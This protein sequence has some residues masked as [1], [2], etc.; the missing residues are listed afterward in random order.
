M[1]LGVKNL[2][3]RHRQVAVRLT[4]R[5]SAT[6][7]GTVALILLHHSL[8]LLLEDSV[9][10]FFALLLHPLDISHF[11]ALKDMIWQHAGSVRAE[12]VRFGS[13]V[14]F[15][16]LVI[17][18]VDAEQIVLTFESHV[19]DEVFFERLDRDE[20][21]LVSSVNSS[22]GADL[23]TLLSELSENL[24]DLVISVLVRGAA[25]S[26]DYLGK[27]VEVD[28]TLF[29]ESSFVH[30]LEQV[31]KRARLARFERSL[32][33]QLDLYGAPQDILLAISKLRW[34]L[35][36]SLLFALHNITQ[37]IN[38]ADLEV[39]PNGIRERVD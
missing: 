32:K 7:S 26:A 25:S 13:R 4:E 6:P 39:T 17:K 14:R 38:V 31:I 10:F 2:R 15:L 27:V 30:H 35:R 33:Q 34:L 29:L 21:L 18:L 5:I 3:E 11:L 23:R 19:V 36:A 28:L 16:I 12:A 8:Q 1:F 20:W 9:S 22:L 24:L 37:A